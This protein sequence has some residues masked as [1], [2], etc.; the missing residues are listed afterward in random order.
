MK[1]SQKNRI[2]KNK[3]DFFRKKVKSMLATFNKIP[4][5]TYFTV[6]TY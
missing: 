3:I 4:Y 5:F 2:S 6:N 1:I